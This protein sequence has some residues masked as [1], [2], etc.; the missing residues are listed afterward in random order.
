MRAGHAGDLAAALGRGGPARG[1]CPDR[2][3]SGAHA[4]YTAGVMVGALLWDCVGARRPFPLWSLVT[5]G[6]LT[7]VPL[8][9]A[10]AALQGRFRLG[11]VIAFT[12]ALG[13]HAGGVL[14]AR[15]DGATTTPIMPGPV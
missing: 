8:L 9:S 11:L 7:A 3:G 13:Q 1:R 15:Q 6:A 2:A 12:L 14:A 4:Y 5:L 10:D